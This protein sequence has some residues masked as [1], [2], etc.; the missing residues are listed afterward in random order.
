MVGGHWLEVTGDGYDP[1]GDILRNGEQADIKKNQMLRRLLQIS[2]LCNNASLH[3]ETSDNKK[4]KSGCR[5]VPRLAYQGR[6]DR[7]GACCPGGESGHYAAFSGWTVPPG[8][9]VAFRFREK[10]DVCCRGAPGRAD[11][12]YEGGADVLV[13]QCSYILWDDKIIRLLPH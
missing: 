12:M 1:R 10:T 8:Q 2:V 5:T 4:K 11:G 6:P 7:G 3:E 9:R 13:Q